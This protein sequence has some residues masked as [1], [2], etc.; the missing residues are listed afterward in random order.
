MLHA[1]ASPQADLQSEP[2]DFSAILA[3]QTDRLLAQHVTPACLKA[4]DGGVFPAA[5]WE[6]VSDAWLPLALVPEAAGGVGLDAPA[7]AQIL[8]RSGYHALPAPL[9]ETML[10]LALWTAAAGAAVEGP[11]S[12]ATGLLRLASGT[13]L[14]EGTMA[15]VPWAGA[16]GHV[17]AIAEAPDGARHLA[18][19][20]RAAY[21][22]VPR[23]NL[24]NEPRETLHIGTAP[25]GPDALLP[26]PAPLAGPDGLMLFGAF[27]R[28]Q[29]MAGAMERCLDLAVA[30][31]NERKQFGKPIGRFQAVQQ[32]LAVAA[33]ESAAAGAAAQVAAAAWNTDQFPFAVAIAKARCGEAAG[34]VAEICHQVHGAMGFTQEHVLHFITR[35]LWAWRDECGNDAHWQERIGRMVCAQGG[36]ALW[37]RLVAL[38]AAANGDRGT[39][40]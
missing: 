12:L 27:A 13:I 3:E 7:A 29:Q 40:P 33:G 39:Q 4:A 24:A 11:V 9:A 10:G 17:L 1:P 32:M 18:L 21:T 23:R 25:L 16:A 19:L 36:A 34:K 20:P 22:I 28:A 30:Y 15:H 2:N 6:A 26:L 5:A 35:R 37:P 14:A 8:R 31:A 38:R